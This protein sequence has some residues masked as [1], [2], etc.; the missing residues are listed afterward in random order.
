[1]EASKLN[2]GGIKNLGLLVLIL[3]LFGFLIFIKSLSLNTKDTNETLKCPHDDF[4]VRSGIMHESDGLRRDLRGAISVGRELS[5]LKTVLLI[6]ILSD[7]YMIVLVSICASFEVDLGNLSA[8]PLNEAI[9]QRH[10]HVLLSQQKG[11]RT[12]RKTH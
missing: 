10:D 1:M 8:I 2:E 7:S 5:C 11:K 3:F 6:N 4:L 12:T 9:V